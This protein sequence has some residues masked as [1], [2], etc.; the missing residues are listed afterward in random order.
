MKKI[1]LI[2]NSKKIEFVVNIPHELKMKG[3]ETKYI[4]KKAMEG[5][6]PHEILYREKQGFGVPVDVW[7][8]EK[9]RPR[10]R[11]TLLEGRT[12]ARGFFDL[13]YVELLLNEHA[14]K[15]R[16]HAWRLWQLFV[17]ELWQRRFVDEK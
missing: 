4:L 13:K 8:N 6:V 5:I 14:A 10:I 16:D 17:F 3:L 12:A 7:I 2:K 15:R 11:E 1:R 9:L